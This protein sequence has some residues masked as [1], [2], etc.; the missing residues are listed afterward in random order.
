MPNETMVKT[1]RGFTAVERH[2]ELLVPY[3]E[4]Y[5]RVADHIWASRTFHMAENLL[6]SLWSPATVGLEGVD[7]AAALRAL[8]EQHAEAPAAF[9]RL[10]K[11]NLDDTERVAAVQARE[12]KA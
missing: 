10:L 6:A 12:L 11:E 8:L 7:P 5:V 2:P 4:R 9:R 3:I 1:L